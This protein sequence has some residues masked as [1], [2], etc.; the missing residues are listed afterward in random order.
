MRSSEIVTAY[1]L[2]HLATICITVI[3]VADLTAKPHTDQ[4]TSPPN[5][6][7]ARSG[8]PTE[9]TAAVS[10]LLPLGCAAQA[11]DS[12]IA[13]ISRLC[14]SEYQVVRQCIPSRQADFAAGRTAARAALHK[15]GLPS[16]EIM[17]DKTGAPMWPKGVVGSISHTDELAIAVV[18]LCGFVNALGV[19]IEIKG[20]VDEDVLTIIATEEEQCWLQNQPIDKQALWRTVLFSAKESFY[21]MQHPFTRQW[22]DFRD[23][24]LTPELPDRFSI[25]PITPAHPFLDR[26]FAGQIVE[27][28]GF[29]VTLVCDRRLDEEKD[30][31]EA[32]GRHSKTK[33]GGSSV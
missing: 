13:D 16:T 20:S 27:T 8:R 7:T 18:G 10:H 23:V 24:C 28:S 4:L 15:L 19:D 30:I 32:E 14:P 1:M 17:A 6:A 21:K 22:L 26:Q 2:D 33:S 25:L 9:V 29:I 11:C 5:N 31:I 3:F 12:T